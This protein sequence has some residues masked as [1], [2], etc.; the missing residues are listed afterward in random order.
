MRLL[1]A[2]AGAL[3]FLGAFTGAGICQEDDVVFGSGT[4]GG[5]VHMIYGD[6]LITS[7]S[8]EVPQSETFL[9]TLE[10]ASSGLPV[11][12]DTVGPGGRFRFIDVPNGEYT[13]IIEVG[14]QE[15]YRETFVMVATRNTDKQMNVEFLWDDG[16]PV[17]DSG[18][19][20]ARSPASREKFSQAQAELAKGNL[21]LASDLLNAV[22]AADPSDYEAWTE[23][24]TVEFQR[25]KPKDARKAYE[26][27]VELK[28]DYLPSHLNLGKLL[29]SEKQYQSAI[30]PLA[31]AVE[32]DPSRAETQ[33]LLGEAYLGVKK[34]SQAVVYLY[35]ALRLD[36]DGMAD[37]HLRLARLYD[38]A[39][40]KDRAA[41]EYEQ[42]LQ[43][44][45]NSSQKSDLEKYIARNRKN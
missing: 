35:E 26:R 18:T 39:G 31:K 8:G 32:L 22:V 25:E 17:T 23:L 7:E 12:R 40:Y 4:V 10:K 29:L 5:P 36:P 21:K 34:G 44:R 43:K 28:D 13:L 20:Y 33:Y 14:D 37:V 15:V 24:G 1:K 9:V 19:V 42:F 6:I 45:P 3:V 38:G 11:G 16:I 41:A 27:A 30:E 2:F